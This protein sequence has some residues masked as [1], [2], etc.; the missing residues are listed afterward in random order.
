MIIRPVQLADITELSMVARKTY[1]ETFGHTMTQK[2]LE[3]ELEATRSEK[4]FT[5]IIDT[6]EILVAVID[7]KLAGYIQICDVRYNPK[8]IEYT[9][10]DQAIH[11]IYVHSDYQGKGVG[12]ALMDAAFEH[13]RIKSSENIFIDV[14]EEN[15]RAVYFYH[16]YGFKDEGHIDVIIDGKKV[17]YDLVLKRSSK[18]GN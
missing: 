4:Y 16:N 7:D 12:R 5:Q 18:N 14:F 10:R 11:A 13:P 1:S 2:E 8:S 17:G 3:E 6:D 9:E 15:T